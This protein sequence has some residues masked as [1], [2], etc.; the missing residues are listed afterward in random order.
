MIKVDY[1]ALAALNTE[2]VE[3]LDELIARAFRREEEAKRREEE[4]L[5]KKKKRQRRY[6]SSSS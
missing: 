6:S 3:E 5:A 4:K 1:A 2:P